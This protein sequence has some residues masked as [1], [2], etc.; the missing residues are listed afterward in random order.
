MYNNFKLFRWNEN[1]ILYKNENNIYTNVYLHSGTVVSGE[2][3]NSVCFTKIKNELKVIENSNHFINGNEW[4]EGYNSMY[5]IFDNI[6]RNYNEVLDIF[7]KDSSNNLVDGSNNLVDGSNNLIFNDANIYFYMINPFVFS[8]S[9]HDLSIMLNYVDYI[10][11]NNIKH[12]L[13]LKNYKNTN[14][15]KLI[16][17]ILPTDCIIYELEHNHIYKIKNIIILYELFH[18]IK[19]YINENL[20]LIDNLKKIAIDNYSDTFSDCYDKNI[21]L[22]KSNRNKNVMLPNTKIDSEE[23]INKLE[24]QEYIY[25]IPEEIDIFKLAI[26]LLFAKKIVFS[27]GSI[28]YTNQIFFNYNAKLIYLSNDEFSTIHTEGNFSLPYN[29]KSNVFTI[30]KNDIN[31]IEKILEY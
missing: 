11:K 19:N 12:I 16:E 4:N 6:V 18:N 7:N 26:Y 9:G 28:L 23:L 30:Y 14:N 31:I 27:T 25:I 3:E 17:K 13:I 24:E 8:N 5:H 21:L 20:Y 2:W 15:Y 22:I 10:I 1:N 29:I